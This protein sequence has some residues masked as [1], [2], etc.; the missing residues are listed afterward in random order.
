ME[1]RTEEL[2][3]DNKELHLNIEKLISENS[4]LLEVMEENKIQLQKKEQMDE[5]IILLGIELERMH[6]VLSEKSNEISQLEDNL[7]TLN[8]QTEELNNAFNQN[9][10]D[11]K[12]QVE[13]NQN[14]MAEIDRLE[15][16]ISQM[17][18][19]LEQAMEFECKYKESEEKIQIL[20]QEIERMK[21]VLQKQDQELEHLQGLN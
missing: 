10:E 5:Q 18:Q 15:I 7:A 3:K 1:V 21:D 12:L 2:L 13:K 11:H 8:N 4:R 14:L 17:S 6:L 16:E 9:I 20:I 19:K